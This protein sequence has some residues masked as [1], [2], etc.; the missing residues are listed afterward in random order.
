MIITSKTAAILFSLIISGSVLYPLKEN[1][2]NLPKDNFPLS[3]YP[4]FSAKRKPTQTLNYLIGYDSQY[5]RY[6]IP[7]RFVSSGGFNQVRRQINK[8]VRNDDFDKIVVKLASRLRRSKE[9]PFNK[10]VSVQLIRGTYHLD[11]Y[12]LSGN[13]APAS[14]K[15]LCIQKIER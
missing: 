1:F 13:K 11:T 10:L 3:Y 9:P 8:K 15:I 2:T 7:Y 12:Y 5:N 14:E 6:T 4:M